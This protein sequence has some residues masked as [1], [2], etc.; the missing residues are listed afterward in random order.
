MT[1]HPYGVLVALGLIV[2]YTLV[3]IRAKRYHFTI[4]DIDSSLFGVV[5]GGFLGARLYHV[6]DYWSFYS[7]HPE[8]IIALWEGGIGIFGGIIGGSIALFFWSRQHHRSFLD[9]V[10]LIA[11][12]FFFGQAVGR[13]GNF[14]NQ[15]GFG[16][17][18]S[19]SWGVWFYEPLWLA[20]GGL[21]L[22]F[23]EKLGIMKEKRLLGAAL[24]WY[25]SG[26]FFI[27]F[28]RTDTAVFEDIKIAQI[29]SVVFIIIGSFLIGGNVKVQMSK[30]KSTSSN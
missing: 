1:I 20:T 28:L 10:T 21:L 3:R 7:L 11:P 25:G 29:L 26:R 9:L 4:A 5:L 22:L 16:S 18:T 8:K 17:S 14:I 19:L 12:A 15:E 23:L 6:L 13:V 24:C 30:F 27:E 2:G